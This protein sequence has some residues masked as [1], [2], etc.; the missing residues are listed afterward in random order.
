V[1]HS[2]EKL[3]E[4]ILTQDEAALVYFSTNGSVE[5]LGVL[6]SISSQVGDFIN[7]VYFIVED[8]NLF[9]KNY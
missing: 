5:D 8:E 7:C 3:E 2:F 6:E 4:L 9:R 1:V